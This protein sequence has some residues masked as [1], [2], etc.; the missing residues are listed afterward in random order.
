MSRQARSVPRPTD[1]A[2]A[3][4]VDVDISDLEVFRACWAS[5][6]QPWWFAT[7]D[8]DPDAAGRFD[9][10]GEHGTCYF[11]DDA[12]A[13]LIEKLTDPD[14]AD[15]LISTAILEALVV[16][17]GLLPYPQSV[18]DATNRKSRL[19]KELG[20]SNHYED[21]WVWA[22]ALHDDGRG[23]IRWWLRLDPGP[24]KGIAVFGPAS[25][26]DRPVDTEQWPALDHHLPARNFADELADS[27]DLDTPAVEDTPLLADFDLAEPDL[28]EPDVQ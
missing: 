13:C 20:A 5:F 6:E 9:L 16:W 8:R 12:V 10:T 15:P 2:V 22:D 17:H 18:A 14:E 26:P 7:R 1:R 24:G 21:S 27:F 25:A 4:V 19:P 11:A 23:G 3:R 28:D